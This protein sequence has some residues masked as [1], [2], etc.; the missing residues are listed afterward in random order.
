M[1]RGREWER[2][3]LL[4]QGVAV[5][6]MGQFLAGAAL[7]VWLAHG[8]DWLLYG[9]VLALAGWASWIG[10]AVCRDAGRLPPDAG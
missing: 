8:F 5:V 1:T 9:P 3:A 7:A 2:N 6:M 10:W 4:G